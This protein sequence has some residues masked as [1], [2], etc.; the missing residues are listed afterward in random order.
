M[1][2]HTITKRKTFFLIESLLLAILM[3]PGIS[4]ALSEGEARTG[5]VIE[6]TPA[7]IDFETLRKPEIASNIMYFHHRGVAEGVLWRLEAS[8]PWVAIERTEGHFKKG[9]PTPVKLTLDSRKLNCGSHLAHLIITVGDDEQRR[10]PLVVFID[11]GLPPKSLVAIESVLLNPLRISIVEGQSRRLSAT[12]V[13]SDGRRSDVSSSQEGRWVNSN[14]SVASFDGRS[15]L[16]RALSPG[17]AAIKRIER[18]TE[19]VVARIEVTEIDRRLRLQV[20]PREVDLG[21]IGPDESSKG[22]FQVKRIGAGNIDCTIDVARQ[23]SIKGGEEPL[24]LLMAQEERSLGISLRSVADRQRKNN[25]E[26]KRLFYLELTLELGKQRVIYQ[27]HVP[28]GLYR[29]TVQVLFDDR[30]RTLFFIYGVSSE[31]AR[32]ILDVEPR[33]L[34]LGMLEPGK[35][36]MSEI[37]VSNSGRSTLTWNAETRG[38]K[39]SS[40]GEGNLIRLSPARGST[41][42]AKDFVNVMINPAGQEAGLYSENIIFSSNG[43]EEVVKLSFEVGKAPTSAFIP[44]YAYS[45]GETLALLSEKITGREEVV[46]GYRREG[47]AFTLFSAGTPGTAE[48]YVWHDPDRTSWFYTTD[49]MGGGIED[50]GYVF[51]GSMGNIALVPLPHTSE[52]YRFY[53]PEARL[54]LYRTS[55]RETDK[56]RRKGYRYDGIAGYVRIEQEIS[57][58]SLMR[59]N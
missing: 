39:A 49:R 18:G 21:K 44:V 8:A 46:R 2:L 25:D 35:V 23:W 36:Y 15:G 43:G 57:R 7:I 1:I 19:S 34:S 17:V 27:R 42:T 29:E 14:P 52:L 40:S 59:M 41:S 33:E 16:L 20:T 56:Q 55:L 6:T 26:G 58:H 11:D 13:W 4:R 47:V 31:K 51:N 9:A 38:R 10:V 22:L 32:P 30:Y 45:N 24:S 12:A 50:I 5:D 53:N 54:Y 28:E 3:I 37:H 48:F